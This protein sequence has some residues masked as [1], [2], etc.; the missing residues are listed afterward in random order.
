MVAMVAVAGKG[1]PG[2]R[3]RLLL[4]F[5]YFFYAWHTPAYAAILLISTSLDFFAVSAG[6]ERP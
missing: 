1:S 4:V 6:N 2:T 3:Q 5:S